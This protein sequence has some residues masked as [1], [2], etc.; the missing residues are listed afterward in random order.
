MISDILNKNNGGNFFLDE[1]QAQLRSITK[2]L[3]RKR[4][5]QRYERA[6]N[7]KLSKEAQKLLPRYYFSHIVPPN[8]TILPVF[9]LRRSP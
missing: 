3:T 8:N 4:E 2:S 9:T 6:T 1:P 7:M 5:T